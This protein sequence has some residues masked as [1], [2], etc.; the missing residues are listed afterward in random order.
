[1]PRRPERE[2]PRPPSFEG[3]YYELRPSLVSTLTWA[4]RAAG[5]VAGMSFS[6]YGLK[7]LQGDAAK[8]RITSMVYRS[9]Q[10]GG[11]FVTLDDVMHVIMIVFPI[12]LGFTK[13]KNLS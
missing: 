13:L 7:R 11:P 3:L 4:H 6:H 1:M 9:G 12:V 2:S 8:R 5:R 10:P